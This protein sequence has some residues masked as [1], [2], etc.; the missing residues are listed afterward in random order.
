MADPTRPTVEGAQVLAI[1][2]RAYRGTVEKQYADTLYLA[3]ELHRQM[4]GMDI[5][6]RGL[7]VTYAAA[8]A[9]VGQLR[10]GGLLIDTLTDQRS[11]VQVLLRAGLRLYAE[12]SA[13][14]AYGLD[15]EGRLLDGVRT[16]STTEAAARWSDYRTVCFL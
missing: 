8:G 15:R 4:G 9:H 13:V 2:E 12:E 11:D 3:A 1:V 14:R 16:I 6:L 10:F 5:L 7:A